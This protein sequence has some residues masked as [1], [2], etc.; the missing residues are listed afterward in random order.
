MLINHGFQQPESEQFGTLWYGMVQAVHGTNGRF[1]REGRLKAN[2]VDQPMSP[3]RSSN[4]H[5]NEHNKPKIM[6]QLNRSKGHLFAVI[7]GLI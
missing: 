1:L 6:A 3:K 4:D 2:S 7:C 5:P